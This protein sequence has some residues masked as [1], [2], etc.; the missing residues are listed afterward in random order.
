LSPVAAEVEDVTVAVVAVV[1][2]A[3]GRH[4]MYPKS[5]KRQ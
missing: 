5:L 4:L 2:Y 1:A 3:L